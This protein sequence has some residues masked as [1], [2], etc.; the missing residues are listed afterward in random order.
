MFVQL[1]DDCRT[2]FAARGIDAI[3]DDGIDARA[4]QTNYGPGT[5]NRVVFEP[6]EDPME[7]LAPLRLGEDDTGARQLINPIFVF[8]VYVAGFDPNANG[9]DLLHR[10]ACFA[11]WEAVVQSVQRSYY[12]VAEWRSA[13]WSLEKRHVVHGAELVATLALNI[14]LFDVASAIAMP[15]PKPGAPKPVP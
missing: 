6:S 1:V 5:A 13:R 11:L 10:R 8:N 15:T 2:Y 4:A 12:G 7:I 14:P 3:V 9:R